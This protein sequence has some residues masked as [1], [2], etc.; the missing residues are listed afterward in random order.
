[1]GWL[2]SLACIHGDTPATGDVAVSLAAHAVATLYMNGIVAPT[3]NYGSNNGVPGNTHIRGRA[4]LLPDVTAAVGW[5]QLAATAG[6]GNAA[7]NLASMLEEGRGIRRDKNKAREWYECAA[8]HLLSVQQ[9]KEEHYPT[10]HATAHSSP[11]RPVGRRK[12]A[13]KYQRHRNQHHSSS[14][15]FPNGGR[16]GGRGGGGGWLSSFDA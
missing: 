15:F 9:Q 4:I 7:F 13:N 6:N 14:F 2:K 16:S 8:H 10:A 3:E 1:M 11:H 5:F 12:K